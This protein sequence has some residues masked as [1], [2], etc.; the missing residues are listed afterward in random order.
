MKLMF[1]CNLC[2]KTAAL[3]TF[4]ISFV[5]ML[6]HGLKKKNGQVS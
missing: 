1:V 3:D 4:A 6:R 5:A 2:R